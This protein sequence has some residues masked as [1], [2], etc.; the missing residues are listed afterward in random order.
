MG[1]DIRLEVDTGGA[2]PATVGPDLGYTYN[3][4]KMFAAALGDVSEGLEHAS[5]VIFKRD[6][7]PALERFR[8][9]EAGLVAHELTEAISRMAARPDDYKVFNPDNGWGDYD[10]ALEFLERF[11]DACAEHPKAKVAMWL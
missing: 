8:G 5:D 2:E 1:Y 4:D 10:G 6:R 7:G 11:R 9:K 3:V